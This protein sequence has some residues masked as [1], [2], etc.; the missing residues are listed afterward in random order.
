MI[1]VIR[2]GKSCGL[3]W[4]KLGYIWE[5]ECKSGADARLAHARSRA[6]ERGRRCL[7]EHMHKK[8]TVFR[9]T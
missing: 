9:A 2:M 3:V 7:V 5:N 8:R 1:Q 4:D 6:S